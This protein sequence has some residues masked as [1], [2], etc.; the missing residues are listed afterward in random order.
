MN[1]ID[2]LT[3][4][5]AINQQTDAEGLKKLTSEKKISLYCGVDPTGDSM[6]IGHLIPFMMMKRFELAGHHPYILIGGA[7]GSIG[8]PSGRKTERQLQTMDKVQHNVKALSRQMQRLFG[9]DS[10][11]TM[12]NN[13]DWLSKISLLDFLR[14]YGKLV[15]IN[16]MLAKDI[17][18]SRLDT[19]ISFTEFTYQ[20]L[21]SVDFLTLHN[22]HN[23][24]LQIGGADQWGNIT[25]GIDLIHKIKGADEAVY[26]L[27]IPLMLKAD[28]TKFGKTAGG[29]I[30]L[31]ADKTSPYEFYQFWL[32]QDDRDV[33]RYL[34]F[35]TFLGQDEINQ[36][37]A[38][39]E[40][41]PEKRLAQRRLAEE[42][43]RFVHGEEA[44]E[45]AQ[46]ISE[47]LFSGDIQRL[48]LT[49]VQEAFEKVPN[50]SINSEPTNIVELLT[51]TAIEPSRRQARE[52]ITNGAITINGERCT[53]T[54]AQLNPKTNFS[55]KF[56]VIRR[57]KKNYF[58]AKVKD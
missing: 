52:D 32:N 25:A 17:V 38:A 57:G 53:D 5:G 16:T 42:V 44:L 45:S 46:H 13:Y 56:M 50:V 49:E 27:T 22:D 40:D 1:I 11:V 48:T 30:W 24:Q 35:F 6:H 51:E 55:G 19:G 58:L 28:G 26:G 21:Q 23:I 4:R 37:A 39:V 41:E 36:L 14:D 29:A 8:D 9:G 34:K 3:W 33:I 15:N 54:D 43:T 18:A 10:N 20:I 12:V 47:I 7:T 2:E 31:D